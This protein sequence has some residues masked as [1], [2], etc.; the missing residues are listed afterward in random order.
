MIFI[1]LLDIVRNWNGFGQF[2]FIMGIATLG[3]TILL[4]IFNCVGEFINNTIPILFRG[5]P[6]KNTAEDADN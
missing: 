3:T 1:E 6:R 4:T 5:Y 2:L